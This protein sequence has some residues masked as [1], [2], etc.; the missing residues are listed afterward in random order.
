[1]QPMT[2]EEYYSK[3]EIIKNENLSLADKIKSLSLSV[4]EWGLSGMKI[5][6][7]DK[8]LERLSVCKSCEFWNQHGF[9]ETGSCK[10]CGC[11]TK[12]KLKM[13]TSKCPIDKWGQIE[14]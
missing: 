6:D 5:V 9:A 14:T 13:A 4:S 7:N 10:K 1:M 11:S 12:V 2:K 8:F 3:L